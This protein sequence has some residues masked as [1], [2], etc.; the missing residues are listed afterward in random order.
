MLI[1]IYENGNLLAR[2]KYAFTMLPDGHACGLDGFREVLKLIRTSGAVIRIVAPLYNNFEF[3]ITTARM[4]VGSQ[5]KF[6]Q[7]KNEFKK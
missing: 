6:N 1:G 5:V 4:Y 3:D 2:G 7:I